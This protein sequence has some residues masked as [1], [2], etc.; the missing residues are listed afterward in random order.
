M[1]MPTGLMM[2][3]PAQRLTVQSWC[4]FSMPKI[5]VPHILAQPFDM[6]SSFLLPLEGSIIDSTDQQYYFC[7]QGLF[8]WT[9]D[10][11]CSV[12]FMYRL[13]P[14]PPHIWRYMLHILP[15]TQQ[16]T[17]QVFYLNCQFS[18]H[19][20]DQWAQQLASTHNLGPGGYG[21]TNSVGW[22]NKQAY[23]TY[24]RNKDTFLGVQFE[25]DW[26]L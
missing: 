4:I 8:I 17:S 5:R 23:H 24:T 26:S 20:L 13:A 18:H 16:G 12:G 1:A 21:S 7:W 19:L 11:D 6:L 14:W 10:K 9:S 25:G 15:G 22:F 2:H 3:Q